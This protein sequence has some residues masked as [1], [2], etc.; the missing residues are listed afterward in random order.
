MLAPRPYAHRVHWPYPAVAPWPV[1]GDP[2]DHHGS[3]QTVYFLGCAL[4]VRDTG[5]H[6]RAWLIR[7]GIR[8]L[9]M[10]LAPQ[11]HVFSGHLHELQ[12]RCQC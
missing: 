3:E 6:F 10:S 4:V 5:T 12:T 11:G 2:A 1:A 9:Q 7:P 8:I